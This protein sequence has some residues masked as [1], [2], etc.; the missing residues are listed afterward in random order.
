MSGLRHGVPINVPEIIQQGLR[1]NGESVRVIGYLKSFDNV[2]M[3]ATIEYELA[4]IK[5]K[6]KIANKLEWHQ[7]QLYQFIGELDFSQR[8]KKCVLLV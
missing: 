5:V 2:L 1:L 8:V 3:E 7:D 4:Q 6:T